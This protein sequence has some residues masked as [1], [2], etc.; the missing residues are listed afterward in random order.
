MRLTATTR[1]DRSVNEVFALWADL[2]RSPE[3]SAASVERRKLTDGP[4]GVGT[5][6]HAVDRWPGRTVQFT[7]EVTA[8]SWTP[9]PTSF[10]M[11]RFAA[12]R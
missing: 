10:G 4:V 5:R 6:Y 12:T 8:F 1:V 9:L 7:V 3:Y 2:T 11:R